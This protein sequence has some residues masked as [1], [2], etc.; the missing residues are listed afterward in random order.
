MQYTN[1]LGLPDFVVQAIANMEHETV[2]GGVSTTEL[3]AP[4]RQ[5]LLRWRH[6]DE[7]TSDIS[8]ALHRARGTLMHY[9]L[10]LT[11]TEGAIKE[12]LLTIP[13]ESGWILS[14]KPDLLLPEG[15][16]WVLWDLKYVSYYAAADGVKP[17]YEAQINI[18]R[19][20]C[21]QNG[22][23]IKSANILYWHPDWSRAAA[24]KDASYPR[25]QI[26]VKPVHLWGP[27]KTEDYVSGRLAQHCLCY[28]LPDDKL[29]D[30][31]PEERWQKDAE[32]AVMRPGRKSAVRCFSSPN[33]ANDFRRNH[34]D[35][36]V[37]WVD[38]REG[39][40]ARCVGY[41]DPAAFCCYR[42]G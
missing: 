16:K 12:K 19:H 37:M 31:T 15:D 1:A 7:I 32:W 36:S 29:P 27:R 17:E 21:E 35:S 14:G 5:R 2:S 13:T 28:D 20:L 38:Y 10:E 6:A 4:V 24:H 22:L 41:C 25:C 8:D 23:P 3:I 33:E 30:C 42:R 9:L 39:V 18:Y 40:S 26:Q 11:H 34:K